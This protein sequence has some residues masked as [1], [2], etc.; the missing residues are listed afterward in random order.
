SE[1]G[2]LTRKLVEHIRDNGVILEYKTEE[3]IPQ[4]QPGATMVYNCEHVTV[5]REAL[6]QAEKELIIVTP[7][8]RGPES[9]QFVKDIV[10]VLE[11]RVKVT[12]IYGNKGHEEND[13]NDALTE[14]DL[15]AL[16]SK[17]SGSQ[18]IRLGR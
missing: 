2:R 16:F 4:P 3:E 10:S 17:H 13:Y 1:K 12:V 15:R 9:R 11:K 14:N 8:I 5:F 18:L 7:W 6:E